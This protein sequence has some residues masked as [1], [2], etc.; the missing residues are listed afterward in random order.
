MQVIFFSD[1][2][3][4]DV[5][6]TCE[7]NGNRPLQ[8]TFKIARMHAFRLPKILHV[9]VTRSGQ[10]LQLQDKESVHTILPYVHML[11]EELVLSNKAFLPHIS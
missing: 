1:L 2:H 8:F 9:S 6:K 11:N 3:F 5:S 4:S 7:N 10:Q